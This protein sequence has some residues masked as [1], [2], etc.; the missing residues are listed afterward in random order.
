MPDPTL[1][2]AL[3]GGSVRGAAHLGAI[4][5]FNDAGIEFDVVAGTSA[6]SI[7]AATYA[8]GIPPQEALERFADASFPDIAEAAFK[9]SLGLFSTD[10]STP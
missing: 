3:A 7:V 2:L 5:V 10:P 8:A 6:G 1:G 4:E 9:N